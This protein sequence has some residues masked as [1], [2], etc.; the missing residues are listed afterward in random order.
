MR[1]SRLGKLVDVIVNYSVAVKNDQLV[2]SS[3]PG[4][5]D[6]FAQG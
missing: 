6:G 1:D 2:R 4:L 5:R 3:G